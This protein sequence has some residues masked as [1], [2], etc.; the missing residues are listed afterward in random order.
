M[1]HTNEERG[2]KVKPTGRTANTASTTK[3]GLFATLCGF[4]TGPGSGAPSFDG[5][6]THSHSESGVPAAG[7]AAQVGVS[8][9]RLRASVRFDHSGAGCDSAGSP[10]R[11]ARAR[12]IRLR[13]LAPVLAFGA[14]LMLFAGVAQA[15]PP[16]L[17]PDGSFSPGGGPLGIAVD[18][19]GLASVG[20]VY[21]ADFSGSSINGFDASNPPSLISPPSP[22]GEEHNYGVAVNPTNGHLYVAGFL[23]AI[24]VYDPSTGELLSSFSVPPFWTGS[25]GLSGVLGNTTQI[26]TN[27]AGDVYV[28]NVPESKVFEYNEAGDLLETFT[29]SGAHALK[30]P[31]GVAVDSSGDVWVADTGDSRVEELSPTGGGFIGEFKSEGVTALALDGHGDVL[32]IVR[33]SADFCG[34]LAPPCAHLVEYSATGAQ[35]ADVGA[36]SFGAGPHFSLR[37]MVA[38]NEATGRVYV[39]DSSNERVWIYSPPLAP[40]VGK[41]LAAEVSPSEAKLGALVN[42]GG[43]ETTYRFEYGTTTAYGQRAPFPEGSVGEGFASR[44]VW[45]TASGLQPGTTYHYRV[46]ATNELA[47]GGVAGPDQ[48]FT[49]ESVEQASCPSNEQ[50]RIGFSARLPDCRAYELVT[51]ST[52]TSVQIENGSAPAVKGE[53][54]LFK[55]Q[56]PLPGAPTGGES[57]VATRGLGGWTSE[58]II[59]P[60]SSTGVTCEQKFSDVG[61]FSSELSKALILRGHDSRSSEPG[62]SLDTECNAEVLQVTSG[63]PVGYENLLLRDNATGAY[64]LLNTL[65]A[66][67]TPADAHLQGASADLSHVVFSELA[68]LTP[69]ASYGV[70][71]LYEWDEGVLRLLT[72]L[73][74]GTATTGSLAGLPTVSTLETIENS[75]G[76]NR[77]ISTDGSHILFTSGGGLYSRIDGERTV[78]VDKTEGSGPSGGGTFQGASADGS[79]VFFTDANKLTKGSTAESAEPDLYECEIVEHEAGKPKCDLTDLTVATGSEHADVLRVSPLGS[80]DSGNVYFTAKG[81]LASNTREYADSE[82]HRVLEGAEN[83]KDNL[84]LENGGTTTFIAMLVASSDLGVGA[85]SPDGSW[86]AF[87]SVK[88][89]TGY[90]NVSSSHAPAYEI[91]LYDAESQQLVCASCNPSGE[92]PIAGA[93]ATLPA[94]AQR[95]LADGGRLFFETEEALVPSDT[96]GQADVYEYEDGQAALI[97]SGT[98]PNKSEFVGASESGSDVFFKSRQQLVPGDAEEEA[99]V[100]YDARAGGGFAEPASPPACTTADACRAPVSSQPAIFGAPSSATFS[101][102]GN[103]TPSA[104][105]PKATP[106]AKVVKCKKGFAKN[107]KGKCVREKTK[108]KRAKKATAKRSSNDRRASR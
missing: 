11:A 26:A 98:S 72:V 86:F 55:T 102:A 16:G 96:N 95:P 46:T 7:P 44:T 27:S 22:F 18:N 31:Q 69:E 97:S 50:F 36:A 74:N 101:G 12:R 71:N 29:G 53:A 20:D 84:Y 37:P 43:I 28:P 9:D 99:R 1:H 21:T 30:R 25:E 56:E 59:P 42:P 60:E 88:S 93:N 62:G 2:N 6:S 64:Q 79:K 10:P 90:D 8:R 81:V 3:T 107:K 34:S 83:G 76:E 92:A 57:Y 77:A 39:T 47:P 100:I 104:V 106:K 38:V 58:D 87:N 4:L 15:T 49:T 19:S 66:G 32:A 68:P 54:I 75:P 48:T 78:Q 108:R 33:N 105:G 23:G 40:V 70:Q 51:P 85:V 24:N 94:L 67:V 17:V 35:L 41:Q 13:V 91:F 73:P 52:K 5:S 63:E 14:L 65:P 89:L 61:A 80:Q 45:A 82:G 103:L